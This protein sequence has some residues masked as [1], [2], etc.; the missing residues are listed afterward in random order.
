MEDERDEG[1]VVRVDPE[2][3]SLIPGYLENRRKDVAAI[4]EATRQGD[5]E[6]VQR[7]GHS[8]KGSGGGYGFAAITDSMKGSGGGYGFAAITEIGRS[9]EQAAKDRNAEAIQEYSSKLGTYL[10]RVEVSYE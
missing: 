5:Y 9:L 2:L 8:M 10:E 4:S 1:T 3:Q 6:T 7:L